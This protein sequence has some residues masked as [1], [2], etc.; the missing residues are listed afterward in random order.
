LFLCGIGAYLYLRYTVPI[1]ESKTTL[2]IEKSDQAKMV[3]KVEN[4][5]D[6]DNLYT[7][8]ELIRSQFILEKSIHR[9]GLNVRYFV[10]GQVRGS[11]NYRNSPYEVRIIEV[12]DSLA[13][14]DKRYDIIF[15]EEGSFNIEQ[16][17]I[18]SGP[19]RFTEEID[20]GAVK[21]VVLL[22]RGIATDEILNR[23]S[24]YFTLP[25]TDAQIKEFSRQ[26][27]VSVLNPT[28]KTIQIS[29]QNPN[30]R[31][32][33]DLVMNHA[34]SFLEF[35]QE[36]KEQSSQKILDFID[37]QLD[38][39]SENLRNSEFLLNAFKQEHKL[40][41][42]ENISD[43]YLTRLNDLEEKLFALDL[44]AQTL[45]RLAAVESGT[46]EN[47][48]LYQLIA[49]T[50]GTRFESSLQAM[51]T[52]L[53]DL[54][55]SKEEVY[56][57]VTENSD[58]VKSLDYRI[59][60]Q[61]DLIVQ[62]IASL[63]EKNQ[64]EQKELKR[65][66]SAVEGTFAGLPT[67][68]L[69]YARFKRLYSINERYYSSLLEKRIQYR[70]SKAGFV[71]ESKILEIGTVPS[72]PIKPNRNLI[73][74]GFLGLGIVLSLLF[75]VIR[76]LLHNNI[77]SL[78]EIAKLSNASIG[79]LGIIPKYKEKIPISQLI[80]D[81]KPKSLI[82]ESFRTVRT[83]LEFL[84]D[85]KGSKVMAIT[86]TISSEGKTFVAL[87]LA[88]I[89]ALSGKKVVILDLDM[90]R[91][92]IHKGFGVDNEKGMSTMLINKHTF[93]DCVR[94]SKLEGLDYITAGPIAPNPSELMISSRMDEIILEAKEKYD[95]VVI[96]NPPV[97]LVTDGIASIKIADYPI[98]IFRADYSKKHF[99]QNVDR[100]I[101]ENGIKKLAV[102]LNNVD[103]ERNKYGS[104]Y[105]YGYG[106]G[107]GYAYGGG[108]GYNSGYYDQDGKK[109][110]WFKQ[111]K[112]KI[113]K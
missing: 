70:I 38:T 43:I 11:E 102:V 59:Q 91:P 60:I 17:G 84:G 18:T 6:P 23:N 52:Q 83:N 45:T 75:V 30:A 15:N 56:F 57:E 1:F 96:D 94:Q 41:N 79:I 61:R 54:L 8:V 26:L 40:S 12:V 73:Y 101:N 95:M 97:G 24:Y 76:Y 98:Y 42:I 55:R 104:Y 62:S 109:S 31:L 25:S 47:L 77:T 19:H 64:N 68:E 22:D 65:R 67:Q 48:D 92:K 107:Y 90:R 14:F 46:L 113:W 33:R 51:L 100:L 110:S 20:L 32:A 99:V 85:V 103:I 58:V 80:I 86:S 10:V 13:A 108:Y 44:E 49:M 3:L 89:I 50:V 16:G 28:A 111:L 37:S 5:G 105:G 78:N 71:S 81:K 4:F 112:G 2:Q 93:E 34:Q 53:A 106:Y 63:R 74:T 36:R 69:E 39:V 66:S 21:I 87:N 82:A 27:G 72:A 7:D 88:G 9:L 35:N 29:Y